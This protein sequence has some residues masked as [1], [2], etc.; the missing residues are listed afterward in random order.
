M[1]KVL[2]AISIMLTA[3]V[4]SGCAA[5]NKQDMKDALTDAF[6]TKDGQD[7]T[8]PD[9][10]MTFKV[11]A[12][13]AS[14]EEITYE[15]NGSYSSFE[16]IAHLKGGSGHYETGK[17]DATLVDRYFEN[18]GDSVDYYKNDKNFDVW[19]L[20]NIPMADIASVSEDSLTAFT[21]MSGNYL[22]FVD[23][24]IANS[25][26]QESVLIDNMEYYTIHT[27]LS[28]EDEA[29]KNFVGVDVNGMK[30]E[31]DTYISV[32]G[33]NWLYTKIDLIG[34][35]RSWIADKYQKELADGFDFASAT[36]EITPYTDTLSKIPENIKEN[37]ITAEVFY[38]KFVKPTLAEAAEAPEVVEELAGIKYMAGYYYEDGTFSV[39]K[40]SS[41]KLSW[42]YKDE[43]NKVTASYDKNTNTYTDADG[44]IENYYDN[45][46]DPNEEELAFEGEYDENGNRIIGYDEEGNPIIE[47]EQKVDENGNVIESRVYTDISK[48]EDV[49]KYKLYQIYNAIYGMNESH[50]STGA[51]TTAPKDCEFA[52]A[53]TEYFNE[54]SL[55]EFLEDAKRY[56]KLDI[57]HQ[58]AIVYLSD[59]YALYVDEVQGTK[60]SLKDLV[61]LSGFPEELYLRLNLCIMGTDW[62]FANVDSVFNPESQIPTGS[63][64]GQ[65]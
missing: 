22:A 21:T 5:Q 59:N 37:T 54:Y 33:H 52:Q 14:G 18:K 36:L 24:V 2:S 44:T 50:Y 40:P 25:T 15:V 29:V 9:Y 12:K 11:T 56:E 8:L 62:E 48:T 6:R 23:T 42:E 57:Y 7:M 47:G 31:A 58:G 32:T 10:Q 34:S 28:G 46:Q 13:D 35:E 64:E 60:L 30:A 4:L 41:Y 61:L 20:Q 38:E 53:A 43:N 51:I 19:V 17:A 26:M 63:E 39:A 45:W 49:Y 55:K 3:V 1:K 65:E 16:N 27:T